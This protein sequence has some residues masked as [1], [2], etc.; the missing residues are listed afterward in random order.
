MTKKYIPSGNQTEYENPEDGTYYAVVTQVIFLGEHENPEGRYGKKDPSQKV[1][2]QFELSNDTMS[3]GRP[4][5]V[6]KTMSFYPSLPDKANFTH[7]LSA[8]YGRAKLEEM[9][10]SKDGILFKDL[11]GEH[12]MVTV[13]SYSYNGKEYSGVAGYSPVPR[14]T[15]KRESVNTHLYYDPDDHDE[16]AY[17]RLSNKAK[18]IIQNRLDKPQTAASGKAKTE[19]AQT[20][21]SDF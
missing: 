8:V 13:E 11:L 5:T 3:D 9:K 17:A 7:L 6:T 4:Y 19:E 16:E 14:G 2:V 18:E 21:P 1:R 20:N 10:K 15:T 12:L